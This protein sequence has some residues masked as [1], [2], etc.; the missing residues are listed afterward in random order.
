MSE[1]A[2]DELLQRYQDLVSGLRM[3]RRAVDKACRVGVL[4]PIEQLGVTPLEECEAIARAIYASTA[5]QNEVGGQSILARRLPAGLEPQHASVS[6]VASITK[7]LRSPNAR[8][9]DRSLGRI[10]SAHEANADMIAGVPHDLASPPN[11]TSG[12]Q[13]KDKL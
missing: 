1:A 7:L 9:L 11:G 2:Y 13:E 5:K 12:F 3:V 4:G 8:S 10:E 6:N